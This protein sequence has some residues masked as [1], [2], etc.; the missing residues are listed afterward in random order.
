MPFCIRLNFAGK[1]DVNEGGTSPAKQRSSNAYT[2]STSYGNLL[3]VEVRLIRAMDDAVVRKE[4]VLA[5]EHV[6]PDSVEWWRCPVEKSGKLV[7][8]PGEHCLDKFLPYPYPKDGEAP[9]QVTSAT[10]SSGFVAPYGDRTYLSRQR[11]RA[12]RKALC[13]RYLF[14]LFLFLLLILNLAAL[15][16]SAL[17]VMFWREGEIP[18]TIPLRFPSIPYYTI[19]I[20]DK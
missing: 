15:I 10:W 13:L 2:T 8:H 20:E 11:R 5:G 14:F 7:I 1:R 12:K 3:S 6:T 17:V 9:L 19:K 4:R 18:L 16:W